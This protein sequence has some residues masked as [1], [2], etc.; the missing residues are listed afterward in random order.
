MLYDILKPL[1]IVFLNIYYKIEVKGLKKVPHDKPI[2]LAPN[3]TNGFVDPVLVAILLKPKV[4]F[5][6]RGDAF[7][8]RVIKWLLNDMHMSPIYRTQDGYGDVRKNDATF[9]E[10]KKLLF[11]HKPIL[12]FPEGLALQEKRLQPLKKGLARIIFQTEEIVAFKKNVHVVPIG[13]N[14]T[15]AKK[16]R[17]K[18]FIHFGDPV[19][20]K[21]SEDIYRQDKAHAI[22]DFTKI[23]EGC[24]RNLIITINNKAND[25]LVEG[26][27]KI[28]LHQW[29]TE[30]KYD[31]KNLEKEF[32]ARREI[33]EMINHLD[34]VNPE[35][36]ESAKKKIKPYLKQLNHHSLRDY[37]LRPEMINNTKAY[38]FI[39]EFMII[40]IGMPLYGLGL[41]MN[42]LPYYIGK[43]ITAK[44]IKKDEFK[45]SV[46]ANVSMLLWL[47]YYGIQLLIVALVFRNWNLLLAY[48]ILVPI[49]GYYVINYYPV[50]KKIF[51]RWR[52]LRLVR[53]DRKAVETLMTERADIIEELNEM[54]NIYL[55]AN[56]KK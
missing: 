22:N 23:L 40:W 54:K 27:Y 15:D 51:G 28:F 29:M 45:A 11:Q 53:K 21:K 14:Y 8:G 37:L 34:H 1:S 52:L 33:A 24:M 10:C 32:K 38:D 50:M 18:V 6:A 5:F 48:S 55:A 2:V 7:K 46:Q 19:S 12:M 41:F 26:I 44:K 3:H 56:I 17:S 49:M 35:I 42:Y 20:I 43:T 39:L 36:I 9:E 31:L 4:R 13:L 47:P 16:F 25:K 30:K